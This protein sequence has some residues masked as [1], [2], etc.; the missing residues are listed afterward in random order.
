MAVYA[1]SVEHR[2][3]LHMSERLD[4]VQ[5]FDDAYITVGETS[6]KFNPLKGFADCPP[7]ASYLNRF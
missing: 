1:E 3:Y 6:S 4:S 7:N 5:W 2:D